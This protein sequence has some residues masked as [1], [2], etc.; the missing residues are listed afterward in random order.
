MIF[1]VVGFLAGYIYDAQR[2]WNAQQRAASAPHVHEGEAGAATGGMQGLPDG[3]PP[4]DTAAVIQT[5]EEHARQN[6]TDPQTLLELANY[7]YD[8]RQWQKSIDWYKKALELN[9]KNINARTDMGT[10][11]YYMGRTRE[12]MEEYSKSL[13]IDPG[14]QP[15]IFNLVVVNLDGTK[16]LAAAEQAWEKLNKLNPAYPGLANMK[17]RLDAARG[18]GRAAPV[19]R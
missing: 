16:D 19:A 9:P 10:A 13:A 12:A 6:P 7:L 4:V 1:F 3:H 11:Y 2:N 18:A 8:Q 15:T 5:L 14:H 17:E